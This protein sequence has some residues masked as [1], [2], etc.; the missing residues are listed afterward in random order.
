ME[1]RAFKNVVMRLNT[2]NADVVREYYLNLEEAMFDYGRYTAMY[3]M[4]K[5]NIEKVQIQAIENKAKSKLKKRLK[6]AQLEAEQEK[7]RAEQAE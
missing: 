2:E 1:V 4:E 7:E 3:M 6:Q 5:S